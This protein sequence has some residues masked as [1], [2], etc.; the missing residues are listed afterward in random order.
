MKMHKPP[1]H[2]GFVLLEALIALAV[3]AV[4]VLG[5]AKLT[6]V[7]LQGAGL[8]KATTEALQIAQDRIEQ[9]RS[10]NMN[11]VGG[12]AALADTT[13]SN[14]AGTNA[15]F[16]VSTTYPVKT[17]DLARVQVCVTWD[18]GT[19]TQPGN[20]VILRSVL[21]CEGSLGTSAMV[22]P[23]GA[24]SLRGD[25][26]KT[27][28]GRGQVG[29]RSYE[30]LPAGAT[31][32][33]I[34]TDTGPVATGTY[35][36]TN[37]DDGTLELL[38]ATGNVLLS[39]RKLGC[40]DAAPGF[41][42]IS[43][44]VFVEAKNGTPIAAA[45]NLFVLSSDASYCTV[46]SY[47]TANWKMPSTAT[48]NAIK[49]FY[50]YYQCSIGAEWWGN[51][52]VIRSDN[53]NSN[54]R[55]CVG[56]P[57]SS[58]LF[59]G[60]PPVP[61][62]FSKHARPSTSRAYRGYRAKEGNTFET[63]GIGESDVVD[64]ACSS[65]NKIV[66]NY[67][68][69]HFRNHDFVH[70]NITGSETCQSL[71]E[72]LNGLAPVHQLGASPA[73]M[74]TVADTTS[75][76]TVTANNNPG[77]YYCMSNDDGVS[78]VNLAQPIGE[79]ETVVSGYIARV[80]GAELTGITGI[81]NA[82][83]TTNW[84]PNG[85][86]G[87]DYTCRINWEGFPSSDWNG[88]ISFGATGNATLCGP[89]T[90]AAVTPSDASVNYTITDRTAPNNANSIVFDAIPMRV[91]N[92]QLNFTVKADNCGGLSIPLPVWTGTTNPKSLSWDAVTGATQYKVH[93]CSVTN[94]TSLTACTPSGTPTVQTTTTLTPSV[95]K[96]D[97]ICYGIKASDGTV[98]SDMSSIRCI[99]R[100]APGTGYNYQ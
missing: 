10:Y 31:P 26:M 88:V 76:K 72:T 81:N 2:S 13:V 11:L 86:G 27:P 41:S 93:S 32:N 91:T 17:T 77:K 12:C 7:M 96:K 80:G 78:C 68:P 97:T 19:C 87:Y 38:D 98:D 9:A 53:A 50:T 82:C 43:G 64:L 63:K 23:G 48:G 28:T 37:P 49:Y 21:A 75:A 5:I 83:T 39:V 40:E 99:Y 90:T 74:P 44:K 100:D 60:D 84:T 85:T 1:R 61:S 66:Y 4:G 46:L 69:H 34:P 56:N 71:L 36:Y 51:V 29:G 79:R 45:S 6:A 62:L 52:G 35:T 8:S 95:A 25:Y 67:K 20:R 3:V 47:D 65:G 24:A 18:G 14:I 55:V 58:E 92:F 33:E 59:I 73:D 89:A 42:T 94:V 70:A 30:G 22:G 57:V 16:A 54:D 15:T